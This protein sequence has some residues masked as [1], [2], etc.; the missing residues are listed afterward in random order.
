MKLHIY[1]KTITPILLSLNLLL[2]TEPTV[3]GTTNN[4]DRN[5]N[6]AQ[7]NQQS[8]QN[9][10]NKKLIKS[11][12]ELKKSIQS[13]N[14][15]LQSAVNNPEQRD[16]INSQDVISKIEKFREEL[17]KI[18]Q[19]EQVKKVIEITDDINAT[20]EPLKDG[21]KTEGV[22]KVQ[23]QL[24]SF[25]GESVPKNYDGKFG[26]ATQSKINNFLNINI[27]A[28]EK[29]SNQIKTNFQKGLDPQNKLPIENL[30]ATTNTD[31][32]TELH[33]RVNT[34][35][36]DINKLSLIVYML[37]FMILIGM[38]IYGYK[39]YLFVNT[40]NKK[41]APNNNKTQFIDIENFQ[42]ELSEVYKILNRLEQKIKEIENSSQNNNPTNQ[43]YSSTY[44]NP[45]THQ[46]ITQNR[47][48][49][50]IHQP[51]NSNLH[52]QSHTSNS[53]SQ[54]LS[55]YNHNSRS[56]SRSA[57]TVSESEYTAEQRRLGR[58]V[59]PILESS[60]RGNYWILA[61]GSHE[62]LFPKGGM[63]I[64]EHNYHTIATFFECVG[65][66]PNISNNFTVVKA[67][68]VSSIGEQWELREIGQLHFSN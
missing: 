14:S 64:N 21:L 42:R 50:Y 39:F 12:E 29:E 20:V 37:L 11:F 47:Q 28:L 32:I 53:N 9:N 63:K 58:S 34:L 40:P 18:Q 61:E 62:Y 16:K 10:E 15:E 8:S 49:A 35:K 13:F 25:D 43:T 55:T 5:I 54:L 7:I 1:L 2:V 46:P 3:L 27:D 36:N 65:Y 56:L 38:G 67:A 33:S 24:A 44:T 30:P 57:I 26:P 60:N 41:A 45:I 6:I 4:S 17:S 48:V 31:V 52:F 68:K 51:T 66:Q 19:T 23:R 22:T 59:S